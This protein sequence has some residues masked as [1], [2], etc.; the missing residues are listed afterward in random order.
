VYRSLGWEVAGTL[1]SAE[2]DVAGLPRARD[3]GSVQLRPGDPGDL[4]AVT[5]LYERVARVHD[6]LLTRR[7]GRF[8]EPFET[9]LPPDVDGVTLA[10]DGGRLVGALLFGRSGGYGPEGR[11]EVRD[12][13]AE[14]PQAA[15]ALVGVLAGWTTV[16][17]TVRVPLLAGDAV[18]AVLPLE[19]AGAHTAQPWMHRPVDVARAVAARGWPAHVRGR[20]AFALTDDAAPWNAGTWALEITDGAGSLVRTSAEPG[21]TLDVRGFAVLYCGAGTGRGV[22]QA[23]L[24]GGPGDPAALDLLGSGPRAQLLDYF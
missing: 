10:E 24:A 5:D 7:G 9:P 3:T 8:D 1:A 4:P 21:L 13:L 12:L 18:S 11:L 2:L 17:R 22:A 14:G 15:R 20:V 19:R 16:T 23:G 6:G